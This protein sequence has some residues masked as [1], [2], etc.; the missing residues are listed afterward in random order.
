MHSKATQQ[1]IVIDGNIATVGSVISKIDCAIFQYV[2]IVA[3]K[4][5]QMDIGYIPD[6]LRYFYNLAK[7]KLFKQ[8]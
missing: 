5:I 7:L 6:V 3:H 1:I 2:V 8:N 4:Q